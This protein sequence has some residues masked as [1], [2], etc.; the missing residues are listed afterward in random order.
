MRRGDIRAL[1]LD[2]LAE[3]PGHGYDL[4][5]RLEARSQ[6]R[7]RPSPGSVYPTLQLLEEGGLLTSETLD[8]KKVYSLTEAGRADVAARAERGF[9][10]WGDGGEEQ[11]G[12]GLRSAITQ[13]AAA[14][15][16]VGQSG[17]AAMAEATATMLNDTRRRIYELL[18][19]A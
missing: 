15:W 13:L 4:I 7:W 19:Q 5:G 8:G 14:A 6:G 3:A 9:S 11:P 1:L 16:Q 12:T 10:P 17:D 18:A 2:V